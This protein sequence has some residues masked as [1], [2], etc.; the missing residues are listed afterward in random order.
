MIFFPDYTEMELQ[1]FVNEMYGNVTELE[2]SGIPISKFSTLRLKPRFVCN[3]DPLVS[4]ILDSPPSIAPKV[5]SDFD[6]NNTIIQIQTDVGSWR[7]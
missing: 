4:S 7:Q 5:E 3:L 1:Q 2:I 6:F